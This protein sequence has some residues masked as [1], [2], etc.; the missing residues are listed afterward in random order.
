[1]AVNITVF[2]KH[3]YNFATTTAVRTN[4][5]PSSPATLAPSMKLQAGSLILT[6][7]RTS[8]I[9][10]RDIICRAGTA[11]LVGRRTN[12]HDPAHALTTFYRVDAARSIE[13]FCTQRKDDGRNVD[14]W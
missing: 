12:Q 14:A 7:I 11:A 3:N 13:P 4:I 5:A 10:E 6:F 1:M 8:V 9:S 2:D